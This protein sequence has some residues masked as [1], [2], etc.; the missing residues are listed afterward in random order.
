MSESFNAFFFSV[1]RLFFFFRGIADVINQRS[2]GLTTLSVGGSVTSNPIRQTP[3]ASFRDVA[4][5]RTATRPQLTPRR[6]APHHT[7]AYHRPAHIG[8]SAFITASPAHTCRNALPKGRRGERTSAIIAHRIGF[9]S[10][11]V[12]S[13]H[14][15]RALARCALA[16]PRSLRTNARSLTLRARARN[17]IAA[18]ARCALANAAHSVLLIASA[19]PRL[20]HDT[21]RSLQVVHEYKMPTI[22][23]ASS[24]PQPTVA[25]LAAHRSKKTKVSPRPVEQLPAFEE[26]RL[27]PELHD[28][29]RGTV[30]EDRDD[31]VAVVATKVPPPRSA[32]RKRRLDDE[33]HPIE[34]AQSKRHRIELATM[35]RQLKVALDANKRHARSS[36]PRERI[37]SAQAK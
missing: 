31:E 3:D 2:A 27:S 22:K 15:R 4:V 7:D 1:P 5:K 30:D 20:S 18:I 35:Q 21:P 16:S 26:L 10:P 13:A 29:D 25:P 36:R 9:A 17:A 8:S 12:N 23:N 14:E 32:T 37:K 28:A 34:S 33:G 24:T 6:L 19:S 11:Q